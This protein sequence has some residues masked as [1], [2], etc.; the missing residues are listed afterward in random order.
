MFF[1]IPWS[2]F[3]VKCTHAQWNMLGGT[4]CSNTYPIFL[5]C[6]PPTVV[7][8]NLSF[9]FCLLQQPHNSKHYFPLDL[10][11]HQHYYDT[12]IISI[13]I[14]G[15][16]HT[17]IATTMLAFHN[18]SFQFICKKSERELYHIWIWTMN[19][20]FSFLVFMHEFGL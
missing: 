18:G 2:L 10:H 1:E 7:C 13:V 4:N 17:H 19:I 20:L 9:V 6:N 15:I 5:L 16:K 8:L 3:N 11:E 12:L 14:S